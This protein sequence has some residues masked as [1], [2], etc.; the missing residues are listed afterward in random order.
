[1]ITSG[2]TGRLMHVDG[3]PTRG[4][5]RPRRAA[6]GE[7]R[8]ARES[9]TR[10]QHS[11][12]G[13]L[14]L[15]AIIRSR[16]EADERIWRRYFLTLAGLVC[17]VTLVAGALGIGPAIRAAHGAGVHGAFI[18]RDLRCTKAGCIW[19]G[20]F[21]PAAGHLVPDAG[22]GDV[23]PPGTHTGTAI[24]ALY[25]PGSKDVFAA[26]NSRSWQLFLM[27]MAAGSGGLAVVLLPGPVRSIRRW[28]G[29]RSRPSQP[30]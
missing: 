14:R 6:W 24:P 16:R 10:G 19:T 21:K 28:R 27:M 12:A 29:Q 11:S 7:A 1:M 18:A 30:T 17:A 20:S 15:L 8:A 13:I 25:P 5:G 22:Y 26:S 9:L 3:P 23:A 4:D 2:G